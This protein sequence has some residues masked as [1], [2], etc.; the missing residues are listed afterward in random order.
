MAA[1]LRPLTTVEKQFLSQANCLIVDG[2]SSTRTVVKKMLAT[3]GANPRKTNAVDSLAKALEALVPSQ[4]PDILIV[5]HTLGTGSGLDVVRKYREYQPSLAAGLVA[6]FTGNSSFS[7][8]ATAAEEGVDCVVLKPFTLNMLLEAFLGA[9]GQKAS[10][11]PYL[12]AADHLRQLLK[13]GRPDEVVARAPGIVSLD[14]KPGLAYLYLGQAHEKLGKSA[15]AAEAYGT[16]LRVH[17]NHSGCQVALMD[18]FLRER[19]FGDAYR[20]CQEFRSVHPITLSMIP[21]F[22]HLAVSCGKYQDVVDFFNHVREAD[23]ASEEVWRFLAAGLITAGKSAIKAGNGKQA[24]E[25]FQK[26]ERAVERQPRLA[27]ELVR[28]YFQSGMVDAAMAL[29]NR[30]GPDVLNDPELQVASLV[31]LD[32]SGNVTAAVEQALALLKA[33]NQAPEV[34]EVAIR[35]SR[36]MGRPESSV[37]ALIARARVAHPNH[38]F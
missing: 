33:G 5:D 22:I 12:V 21:K 13:D 35:R 9:V 3:L 7:S 1:A 37:Q 29:M 20:I 25:L 26:A 32:V 27:R 34:F 19:K 6:M 36:D 8:A 14:P 23:G 11:S 18:L 31:A 17:P 15:D 24:T 28:A 38:G 2:S 10:P 30:L 4:L 16:G